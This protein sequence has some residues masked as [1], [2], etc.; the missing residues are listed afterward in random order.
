[1]ILPSLNDDGV[2]PLVYTRDPN[3][4]NELMRTLTAGSDSIRVM[5]K[6]TLPEGEGKLYN[7]VSAGLVTTGDKLNVINMLLLC[8]KYVRLQ[9]RMAVTELI[10]MGVGTVLAAVLS[11]AGL[12]DGAPSMLLA[13]WHAAWCV[14]LAVISRRTIHTNTEKKEKKKK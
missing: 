14:V 3:V 1:M 10:A 13:L 2:V 8:K 9:N 12:L 6:V 7:S 11:L 4:T 5:K